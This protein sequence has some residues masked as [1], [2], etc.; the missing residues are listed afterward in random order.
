MAELATNLLDLDDE[1]DAGRKPIG[2]GGCAFTAGS[3]GNGLVLFSFFFF[4]AGPRTDE[5]ED[6]VDME[7][8]VLACEEPDTDRTD[9]IDGVA[10]TLRFVWTGA[11]V[12]V[13]PTFEFVRAR[14]ITP[15]S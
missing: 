10:E 9:A 12:T 6:I 7:S 5:A 11:G 13:R 15:V 1:V 14:Y 4:G 2:A 3:T 8:A